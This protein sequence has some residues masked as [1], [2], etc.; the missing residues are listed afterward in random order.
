MRPMFR[1][2]WQIP[3]CCDKG[4]RGEGEGHLGVP[5]EWCDRKCANNASQSLNNMSPRATKILPF[6]GAPTTYIS[7]C[8]ARAK[9]NSVILPILA[10]RISISRIKQSHA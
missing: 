3:V 2:C 6:G 1:Y 7:L 4:R 8:R 5:S 9:P 10:E